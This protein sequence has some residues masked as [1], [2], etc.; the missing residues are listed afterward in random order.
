MEQAGFRAQSVTTGM[1][2]TVS[3][4]KSKVWKR[5]RAAIPPC[6]RAP[7]SRCGS[8]SGASEPPALD[9][10]EGE[11]PADGETSA[12]FP[13]PTAAEAGGNGLFVSVLFSFTPPFCLLWVPK[14]EM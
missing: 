2:V 12:A 14:G 9:Q 11:F 6:P 1:S 10:K 7:A 8:E 4:L 3:T 5:P 13:P